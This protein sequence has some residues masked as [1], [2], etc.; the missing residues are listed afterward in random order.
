MSVTPFLPIWAESLEIPWF[1]AFPLL[2]VRQVL[3][4]DNMFVSIICEDVKNP[5]SLETQGFAAFYVKSY[6]HFVYIMSI[7]FSMLYDT[8]P[9]W[10]LISQ[11]DKK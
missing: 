10:L 6:W 4:T 11:K 8:F 3:E 1:Q 7:T 5:E 9:H 2:S